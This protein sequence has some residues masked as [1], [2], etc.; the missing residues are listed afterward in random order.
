MSKATKRPWRQANKHPRHICDARGFKIAKCLI[1]TKGANFKIPVEEAEANAALIVA[2]V[3]SYSPSKE[4]AWEAMVAALT[5]SR[6]HIAADLQ[7]ELESVCVLDGET[8]EPRRETMDDDDRDYVES[9]E[10]KLARIDRA[11]SLATSAERET[12]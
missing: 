11:L 2:A 9:I 8:F 4:E 5:E 1:E 6:G 10:A 7:T 3:N 12:S